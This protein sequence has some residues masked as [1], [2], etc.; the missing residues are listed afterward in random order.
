MWGN[1]FCLWSV[2]KKDE[3]NAA[4]G[5]AEGARS[6]PA[7]QQERPHIETPG[8]GKDQPGLIDSFDWSID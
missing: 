5:A 3:P 8:L 7:G 6:E 1:L 4:E 2:G